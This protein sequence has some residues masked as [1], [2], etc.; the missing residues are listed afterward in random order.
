M[1]EETTRRLG[2]FIAG[3][4]RLFEHRARFAIAA[5][6]CREQE[7]SFSRF[8][9]L[10]GESDGNLG[11]QLRRLEAAGC[12]TVEKTFRKRKPLSLYRI[13]PEGRRRLK[14][15]LAALGDMLE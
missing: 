15:H 9:A 2:D 14:R 3:Y 10:L 11:A 6:L 8:K 12:V 7:I 1:A 4:D 5:L 13:T